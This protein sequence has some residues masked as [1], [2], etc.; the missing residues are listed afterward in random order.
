MVLNA[1]TL[2]EFD[3]ESMARAYAPGS[4]LL[5]AT[6]RRDARDFGLLDIEKDTIKAFR[7][8]PVEPVAGYVNA[9]CY[10][11]DTEHL[12]RLPEG[13]SMLERDLF[14]MLATEGALRAFVHEGGWDDL[15]TEERLLRARNTSESLPHGIS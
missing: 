13:P 8:K 5:A 1:D 4:S 14:P 2:A 10:I 3:F 12:K 9:G 15:G 7:E 11:L 6:W